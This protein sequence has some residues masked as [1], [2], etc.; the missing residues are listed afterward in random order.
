MDLKGGD[1]NTEV[2]RV[3]D[4]RKRNNASESKEQGKKEAM[5]MRMRNKGFTLIELL[6][7]VAIIAILAAMLL[8]ALSKA[9]ERARTA[10][11]MNNL[12]Q[13]GVAFEM[14]AQ[15][16]EQYWP[17]S[18]P[19]GFDSW[20]VLLAPYAGGT[21]PYDK[22]RFR[23]VI[24]KCPSVK[25]TR[26]DY[27]YGM[28]YTFEATYY[29]GRVPAVRIRSASKTVLVADSV[30]TWPPPASNPYG[31]PSQR[32]NY[33]SSSGGYG[34]I[35]LTRHNGGSN[36]LFCDGHVEWRDPSSIPTLQTNI[37]WWGFNKQ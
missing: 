16:N 32:I 12:K 8:P 34:V 33:V 10:K 36:C 31:Y 11:C 22:D 25:S 35:D 28:N 9:R 29:A 26:Y 14:Y 21:L 6:V 30:R 15:D 4:R 24:W 27:T 17:Q 19:T 23:N 18:I 7:V 2:L 3:S 5:K 1:E 37:F 13:I 20:M